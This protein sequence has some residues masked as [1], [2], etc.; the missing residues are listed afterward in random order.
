MGL[1]GGSVNKL[2]QRAAFLAS[3]TFVVLS[4]SVSKDNEK[5]PQSAEQF[6]ASLHGIYRNS[7]VEQEHIGFEIVAKKDAITFYVFTPLHLRD[8]IEGQLYAQY[9]DLQINQVTDY[10][11]SVNLEGQHVATTNIKLTK[12][13]VYP[14]K[15]FSASEVDPLAGITA[16]LSGLDENEQVWLQIVVRPIGD[17]WQSKGVKYVNEVRKTG[18]EPGA[19][20]NG[21]PAK[22]GRGAL[23]LV[24]EMIQPGSGSEETKKEEVKLS[25]P[26]EA[27]LKGIEAKI[28][29]LGFETVFRVV[30]VSSNE[31]QAKARLQALLAALKQFNTTNLNGFGGNEIKLDDYVSWEKYLTREFEEKGNILNIEELASVYHF[32]A[33]TVETSAISWAGSKKGEAPFNLPLK[34]KV[35]ADNLTVLGKTDFRSSSA[36]FGIKMDDRMRHIYVIGKSGT[37]KSTLLENMVIDD[38]NAGRGV[39]IVDP[40]GELADKAASAVPDSRIQDVIMFEPSDREFP[41]A[42][43]ILDIQHEDQR[44][45]IASGFVAALKKIFGNSWGPRL[46]YILR[47]ATLAIL[48]AENP[49]MLGIPRM[50]TDVGY[51]NQVIPQIKDPVVLDFWKNEWAAKEQK[52][53][54][55]EMGSILNKVGQFLSSSLIR[56]IV[57]QPDSGFDLRQVM[58]QKKIFIANLSKGKIGEDNSALLGTLLIAKVQLA[59]M[60][61][62]DVDPSQRPECFLY[63]DEFQN[64]A[65]E[66]FATILSEARKYNL[67]LTIA[68]QYIAQM[69]PEVKDAVFGNV[70]S[71]VSFRVGADDASSLKPE[72]APVFDENDLVNLQRGS[73]YIK[74]LIDGLAVPAFSA[75]TFP[76]KKI[77]ESN[78]DKV[79][80]YSRAHYAKTKEEAV[81]IIDE[82][83]GYRKRREADEAKQ[84]AKNSLDQGNAQIGLRPAAPTSIAAERPSAA[85]PVVDGQF[86]AV[87]P[88]PPQE[89]IIPAAQ[90][91]PSVPPAV[92]KPVVIVEV[93]KPTPPAVTAEITAAKA[94]IQSIEQ[95]PNTQGSAEQS[96]L[97]NAETVSGEGEEQPLVERISKPL[98][99]MSGWAYKEVAQRGGLK[100]YLGETEQAYTKRIE[101]KR[102]Q[103]QDAQSLQNTSEDSPAPL[104]LPEQRANIADSNNI[105]LDAAIIRSK[106]I[107]AVGDNVIVQT[108]ALLR[109]GESVTLL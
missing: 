109:N 94:P 32:P 38:I 10:T 51:R 30:A 101:E 33:K 27:A 88:Q 100:W 44:G 62:A 98:R 26:Q 35:A 96:V 64:F 61:R 3:Q 77:A 34:S 108:P 13:D 104:I 1:L 7:P 91:V 66:S 28:T 80:E 39:I 40:H 82:T 25:S 78:F 105:D 17:E 57:G 73:V 55:E 83:A 18:K 97:D 12:A 72:F 70:G 71:M 2:Q 86:K 69:A 63:V 5:T 48:E 50:L 53:Q 52:Q 45:N 59:A 49:T 90:P 81:A 6:F 92:P 89:R 20:K 15:L 84:A 8:F 65:T 79:V 47:N 22:V 23:R 29:K 21:I 93:P 9:P 19:I 76:P 24:K 95:L 16:V 54:V 41:V 75:Q 106:M 74:L 102:Q 58:D 31:L 43:N 14:I 67:G 87:A 60:S 37:G 107:K 42:F 99:V 4:I 46:E 68:H 11:G 103:Y 85:K 36:E 56:N